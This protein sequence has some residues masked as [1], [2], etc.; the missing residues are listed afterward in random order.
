MTVGTWAITAGTLPARSGFSYLREAPEPSVRAEVVE[1]PGGVALTLER[2]T[3]DV[4]RDP[5]SLVFRDADGAVLTRQI[6]DDLDLRGNYLG[7]P[8]GFEI[9]GAGQCQGSTKRLGSRHRAR[10]IP[11]LA[12]PRRRDPPTG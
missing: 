3:V 4:A 2:L 12:A 6:G 10:S 5:W 9:E 7:P 8:P 11:A 1:G